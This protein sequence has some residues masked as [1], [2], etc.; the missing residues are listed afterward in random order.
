V[1]TSDGVP[2]R[3]SGKTLVE[4]WTSG[5]IEQLA[6]LQGVMMA[7]G[8]PPQMELVQT[9]LNERY[10]TLDLLGW[11]MTIMDVTT[12]EENPEGIIL[13]VLRDNSLYLSLLF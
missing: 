4:Y 13:P 7:E 12:D 3:D 9:L 1:D 6:N 10:V 11:N 8:V 5:V 2:L